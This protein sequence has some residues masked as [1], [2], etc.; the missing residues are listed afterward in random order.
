VLGVSPDAVDD[1]KLG[2]VYILRVALDRTSISRGDRTV[3]VTPGMMVTA[4][5]VTGDRS[6]FSYL[7]SPIDEARTSALRE[8]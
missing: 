7:T 2:P 1:E 8:R 5:I 3:P 6:F 4:D